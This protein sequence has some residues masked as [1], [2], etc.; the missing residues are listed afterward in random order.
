MILLWVRQIS[1]LHS[2]GQPEGLANF[3]LPSQS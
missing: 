2:E 3:L 1:P